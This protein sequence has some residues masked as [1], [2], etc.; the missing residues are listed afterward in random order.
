MFASSHLASRFVQDNHMIRILQT[1]GQVAFCL[2]RW[3]SVFWKVFSYCQHFVLSMC[4]H[5]RFCHWKHYIST[6]S[7]SISLMISA[8]Q[9]R[10]KHMGIWNLAQLQKTQLCGFPIKNTFFSIKPVTMCSLSISLRYKITSWTLYFNIYFNNFK[11]WGH[12]TSFWYQ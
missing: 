10:H 5:I 11:I 7:P 6:Y 8:Q 3:H 9:W 1:F 12:F 4:C 2:K